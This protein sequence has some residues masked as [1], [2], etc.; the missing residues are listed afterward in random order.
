MSVYLR[1][2]RGWM[3]DFVLKGE[4]YTSNYYKTKAEAKRAEAARREELK[5]PR[6][7]N[8]NHQEIQTDM[9]FLELINRRLDHVKAYNSE[10]HYKEYLYLARYWVKRWGERQCSE[11]KREGIESFMVERSSAVTK[12]TANKELRY[13]RATFNHGKKRGYILSNPTDNIDF[14]PVEKIIKYVPTQEDINKVLAVADPAD[15]DYLLVI[16]D[17]MA[18]VSEVNRLTW[19]DVDFT[20]RRI[21]L[22]TRKKKGGHL[23]PR[24]I[25]MTKR[26]YNILSRNH[27]K[28]DPDK[29]W[30]FWHR[31][32]STKQGC[33]VEGPYKDR[34]KLMR[35]LCKKAGVRYFRY[36]PMRHS[37]ASTLD[38]E[39]VPLGDIQRILGHENRTTT[40]IYLHSLGGTE[41]DAMDVFERVSGDDE[42]SFEKKSQPKSQP[43]RKNRLRL[44]T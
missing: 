17:T 1:K 38:Q 40:E 28:R 37:G 30:V 29:P 8:Q 42:I 13:L 14:L 12:S 33:W 39:R 10:R 9:A 16:R 2:G 26:L 20:S 43:K 22:Y 7:V 3:Y 5:N 41:R 23:T 25:P 31:Y 18:R 27:A 21:T 35:W 15:R 24:K 32:Y 6:P 34:K 11:I 19:D 4:R 44:V 36:H